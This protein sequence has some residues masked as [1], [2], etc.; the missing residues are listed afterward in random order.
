M[1]YETNTKA[2]ID[3]R[4]TGCAFADTTDSHHLQVVFFADAR[5]SST[6]SHLNHPTAS[7]GRALDKDCV[8]LE[9]TPS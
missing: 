6:Q 4:Y 7:P 1:E 5:T 2:M 9:G 3:H 8:V